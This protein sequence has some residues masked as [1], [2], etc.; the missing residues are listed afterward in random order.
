MEV[1]HVHFVLH[2]QVAELVGRTEG[3]AGLHAGAGQPDGEAAG[4][5]VAAGAVLLGVGRA[6]EFAAPPD[7][8]VF[9]QPAALQVGEQAGDRPVHGAGVVGVLGEV[10]VLVPGGVGGAVAVGH[11][12][13]PHALLA[14]PTRQ[15]ALPAEVVGLG[16]ADPVK[17]LRLPRLARKVKDVRGALLHAPGQL[18]RG[19]DRFQLGVSRVRLDLFRIQGLKEVE[20]AAACGRGEGRVRQVTDDCL[21]RRP[22]GLAQGRPL[23]DG[24][25]EGVAVVPRAAVARRRTDRHEAGEVLVLRP[26]PVKHPRSHRRPDRVRGPAMEEKRRRPVRHPL[27]VHRVDE[28]EVVGMPADLGEERRAPAPAFAVSREGP[29]RLHHPLRRAPLARCWR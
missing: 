16:R 6:A 13:E 11:L 1:V 19:D 28:A 26:E 4:V 20:M 2:G 9:Q 3:E 18:V 22:S 15:Q 14:E 7:Q 27:G 21:G 12:D 25:E 17:G 23:V 8:G 29:G 24:G 5:V 10:R